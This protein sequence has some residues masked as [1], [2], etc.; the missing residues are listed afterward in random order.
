MIISS[1]LM[2]DTPLPY[3]F[4]VLFCAS[5]SVKKVFSINYDF[6]NSFSS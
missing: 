5:S 3:I 4:K 2:L 1:R 6:Y